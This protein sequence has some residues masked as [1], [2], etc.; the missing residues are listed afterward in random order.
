MTDRPITVVV[1]GMPGSGNTLCR[2]HVR[3]SGYPTE[4]DHAFGEERWQ[5]MLAKGDVFIRPVRR[6]EIAR[7]AS[8]MRRGGQQSLETTYPGEYHKRLASVKDDPTK[9]YVEVVFEAIL[10]T[11]GKA[12]DDAMRQVGLEPGPWPTV[13]SARAETMGR[14]LTEDER[15][16]FREHWLTEGMT[17]HHVANSFKAMGITQISP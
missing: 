7:R 2:E 9:R 17:K 15:A 13:V 14:V 1:C 12:L 8:A 10:E 11:G 5:K 6:N 16:K 3:R 4:K